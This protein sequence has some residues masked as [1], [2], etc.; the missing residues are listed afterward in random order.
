MDPT[1]KIFGRIIQGVE[2]TAWKVMVFG[3]SF[4][5]GNTHMFDIYIYVYVY[6][7]VY[8]YYILIFYI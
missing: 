6:I 1:L 5:F 8:I 3:P 7:Y 4:F 2:I